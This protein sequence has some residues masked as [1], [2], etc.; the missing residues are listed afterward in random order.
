MRAR[1]SAPDGGALRGLRHEHCR[2]RG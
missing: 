1:R 2:S